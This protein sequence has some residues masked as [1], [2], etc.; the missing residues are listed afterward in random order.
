MYFIIIFILVVLILSYKHL[1]NF[2]K[3]KTVKRQ[4]EN[5]S[6]RNRYF[7]KERLKYILDYFNNDLTLEVIVNYKNNE[8][9]GFF[10]CV[11][12]DADLYNSLQFNHVPTISHELEIDEFCSFIQSYTNDVNDRE[13]VI[14][15]IMREH[16][17]RLR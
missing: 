6:E 15:N 12:K 16:L 7:V 1:R 17:E 2:Y 10:I 14:K 13:N 5:I 3:L 11:R 8:I 9:V 4:A